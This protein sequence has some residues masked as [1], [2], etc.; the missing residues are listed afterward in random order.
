MRLQYNNVIICNITERETNI[1]S[2][3]DKQ[4]VFAASVFQYF[5]KRLTIF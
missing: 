3:T 4:T 5:E 1:V 2:Q